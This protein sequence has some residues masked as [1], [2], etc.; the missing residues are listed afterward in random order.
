M[1]LLQY[2]EQVQ[3]IPGSLAPERTTPDKWQPNTN[4]PQSNWQKAALYSA[5]ALMP[6]FSLNLTPLQRIEQLKVFSP[7]SVVLS[8]SRTT[9]YQSLAY[10]V[11]GFSPK[12]RIT[13]D[14]W[15]NPASEPVRIT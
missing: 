15:Y 9:Q 2:Q 11:A 4:I 8:F 13:V 12:E 5:A 14:K 7:Q 3:G 6:F 10:P 1:K